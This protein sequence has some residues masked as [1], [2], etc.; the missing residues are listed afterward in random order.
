[1]SAIVGQPD[2]RSLDAECFRAELRAFLR[3]HDLGKPPK[4]PAQ[5]LRW[6][7]RWCALLADH[8]FAGPSW[9]RE[10]GGMDLPFDKQVIYAEELA[11]ARIPRHPGNGVAIAAPTII[12][13]G[14]DAQKQRWLRPLLRA[15][16]LWAQAWSEPEAGSDLPS[17]RTTARRDGERYLVTGTKLWSTDGDIADRFFA[18]VRTGPRGSRQQGIT[19]LIIDAHAPGVEVRRTQD[20]T[21]G[22]DFSEIVFNE[23]AVP[24][25]DRVGPENGGW[26][27]ARTSMGHERAASSL[28]QARMYARVV[29]ELFALAHETGAAGDPVTRQ[30]LA[31]AQAEV[32]VML[33]RGART[34]AE[35]T[36]RGEPGPGSSLTRLFNTQAEQSLHELA[37]DILGPLAL[38]GHDDPAAGR[39]G[40]WI[41]GFLRTRASTIGAGTAEIQRNTIAER[42]LELPRDPSMP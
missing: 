10:Y 2:L 17:L 27:I 13:H 8:G 32:Q 15:D 21:G 37:V 35:I 4:D 12:Q 39:N 11:H 29:R 34:I 28:N 26:A 42:I 36:A 9:P 20:M 14:T 1:M 19:Y 7:R 18:L 23:V 3:S 31:H 25:A 41:W 40:R 33:L 38:R 30:R 22:A 6:R 5:R 16:E 24:L